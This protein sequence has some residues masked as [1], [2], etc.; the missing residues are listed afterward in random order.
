MAV[1]FAAFN[2]AQ[3][4]IHKEHMIIIKLNEEVST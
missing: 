2:Y 4:A 1:Y 3:A